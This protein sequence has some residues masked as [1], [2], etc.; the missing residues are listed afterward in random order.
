VLQLH[1]TLGNRAV[2]QFVRGHLPRQASGPA[3]SHG[4]TTVQPKLLLGPVG[5]R[6]EQEAD[7]VAQQVV[8]RLDTEPLPAAGQAV[9]R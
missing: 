2:G 9:Q 5:D 8:Q 7:R 1:R 3:A 4:G 6:Y